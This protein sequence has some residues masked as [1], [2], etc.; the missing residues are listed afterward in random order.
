[1]QSL[2]EWYRPNE[3]FNRCWE[4]IKELYQDESIGCRNHQ[5]K[6]FEITNL[7]CG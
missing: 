5:L 2:S 4:E 1:M 6:R 3:K 7:F